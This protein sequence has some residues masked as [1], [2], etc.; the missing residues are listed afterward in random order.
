MKQ[1]DSSTCLQVLKD[2]VRGFCEERDWDRFHGAKE[3]AIGISTEAGELLEH[4]RFLSDLEVEAL[5]EG[6]QS[7]KPIE[8]ELADVLIFVLRFAQKYEIDL[9]QAVI[10]KLAANARRYPVESAR[11]SNRKMGGEGA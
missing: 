7:Q 9:A 5:F 4:F 11:G 2:A 10:D 8:E 6:S 1:S 3:L